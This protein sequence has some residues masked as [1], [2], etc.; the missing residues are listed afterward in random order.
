MI[1]LKLKG[2]F[3]M[4]ELKQLHPTKIIVDEVSGEIEYLTIEE[5]TKY[6]Y[7]KDNHLKVETRTKTKSKDD[8]YKYIDEKCGSFY[9]NYYDE[10]ESNQYIFRYIYLCTYLNYDNYLE[11]GNS[12]GDNKLMKKKDLFEVLKLSEKETYR[13]MKYFIDYNLM[14][15][16]DD[17]IKINRKICVKGKLREKDKS[18]VRVFDK[19]IQEIYNNSLPKEHKKLSLL[20]KLLP[21]VH[22][23]MNVICKNTSIKNPSLIEP[24]TIGELSSLSGYSSNQKLKKGLMELKVNGEHVVM[25]TK[26]ANK[27]MVV[28]NPKV[29]YKG[30]NIG[31][32]QGVINL[33]KIIN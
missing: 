25:I 16:K 2:V 18:V 27:D 10:L 24:L 26:I 9:F 17:N 14:N 6:K 33:F 29:Y 8:F 28:I 19:A 21:Y 4:N 32:M 13:T 3:N 20:I 23:D 11:F 30:N 5:Y 7:S 12:K 22:F 15:I 31:E 1:K